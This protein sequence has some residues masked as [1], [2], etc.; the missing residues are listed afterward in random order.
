MTGV[1]LLG[2]MLVGALLNTILFGVMCGQMFT[3]FQRFPNDL[4]WIRLFIIYLLLVEIAVVVVEAG[5][6]YEPMVLNFGLAKALEKHPRPEVAFG[7]VVLPADPILI[8]LVST[9]IQVF[10]AWRIRVVTTSHILPIAICVLSAV[11]FGAGIFLTVMVA[12]QPA[13]RAFH[14]FSTETTVWLVSSAVCDVLIAGGMAHAL[15]TRKTG[16]TEVDGHINRIVRMSIETGSATAIAAIIDVV[17]ASTLRGTANFIVEFPLSTLYTCSLLA[18]LNSRLPRRTPTQLSDKEKD[19]GTGSRALLSRS[20][21]MYGNLTANW[22]ALGDGP[23]AT[24]GAGPFSDPTTFGKTNATNNFSSSN[25]NLSNKLSEEDLAVKAAEE[26]EK[27]PP[28]ARAHM[29]RAAASPTPAISTVRSRPNLKDVQKEWTKEKEEQQPVITSFNANAKPVMR[30][31]ILPQLV[32]AVEPTIETTTPATSN[33]PMK[34]PSP[35]TTRPPRAPVSHLR[36]PEVQANHMPTIS[37]TGVIT[38]PVPARTY[39][40]R[41]VK[42]PAHISTST[43]PTLRSRPSTRDLLATTN[44]EAAKPESALKRP[45]AP[46][47]ARERERKRRVLPAPPPSPLPVSAASVSAGI[48]KRAPTRARGPAPTVAPPP[49]PSSSAPTPESASAP[50]PALAQPSPDRHDPAERRASTTLPLLSALAN[51][52]P[53]KR[54]SSIAP[55]PKAQPAKD[56]SKE[57]LVVDEE[58]AAAARAMQMDDGGRGGGRARAPA[59]SRIRASAPPT[60]FAAFTVPIWNWTF[61]KRS[62]KAPEAEPVPALPTPPLVMDIGV[63]AEKP[64]T[65]DRSERPS[66]DE[67]RRAP[68]PTAALELDAAKAKVDGEPYSH[69]MSRIPF[70][71]QT[72]TAQNKPSRKEVRQSTAALDLAGDDGQEAVYPRPLSR[73]AVFEEPPTTIRISFPL[74][75]PM[76]ATGTRRMTNIPSFSHSSSH[77]RR[78][79][80]GYAFGH[81]GSS[82]SRQP[83]HDTLNS[84]RG[85]PRSITPTSYLEDERDSTSRRGSTRPRTPPAL[86]RL[87]E[88]ERNPFDEQEEKAVE[89]EQEDVKPVPLSR[90]GSAR[91]R[92]PPAPLELSAARSRT[93]L[94]QIVLDRDAPPTPAPT[95][96]ASASSRPR[97]PPAQIELDRE[98]DGSARSRTP[99]ATVGLGSSLRNP[100]TRPRTP[101]ARVELDREQVPVAESSSRRGSTRPRTPT[102]QLELNNA[103]PRTPTAQLELGGTR[104]RTPTALLELGSSRPRTPPA[105]VELQVNST[106]PRTPPAQ[107]ELN[108]LRPRTPPALLEFNSARP[109]T[110]PAHIELNRDKDDSPPFN[111][112]R[113]FGLGRGVRPRTPPAQLELAESKRRASN[114]PGL[115]SSPSANRI[116]GPSASANLQHKPSREDL[117]LRRMLS[118]TKRGGI[119]G[120]PPP[121]PEEPRQ[122]HTP[123]PTAFVSTPPS[124]FVT[125][126]PTAFVAPKPAPIPIP[127]ARNS[128][129]APKRHACEAAVTSASVPD[130]LDR[131]IQEAYAAAERVPPTTVLEHFREI[132]S[133]AVARYLSARK[134]LQR[135]ELTLIRFHQACEHE[136]T[137]SLVGNSIK[138]PKLQLLKGIEDLSD[139]NED[140]MVFKTTQFQSQVAQAKAAVGITLNATTYADALTAYATEIITDTSPDADVKIW[141][142]CILR[143][144]RAFVIEL[145]QLA[146]EFTAKLKQDA[147]AKEMKA[148]AVA[149]ANH[150][151]D[152]S[153]NPEPMRDIVDKGVKKGIE[154]L[155]DRVAELEKMMEK[156]TNPP[157]KSKKKPGPK[158]QGKATDT[159]K[160]TSKKAHHKTDRGEGG[161]GSGTAVKAKEKGKK[162]SKPK[163][164]PQDSDAE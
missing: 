93:P 86:H 55:A 152:T 131:A 135:A 14:S 20:G 2:P 36:V 102:A 143:F 1:D 45:Q 57:P 17:L 117:G 72:S 69:R 88:M 142:L 46:G 123:P 146:Y 108:G 163:P 92:T 81:S 71:D 129:G 114:R 16:F 136:A 29:M 65:M 42:T 33:A 100:F 38:E 121:S 112:T 25:L 7:N 78:N 61:G 6:I 156:K 118:A 150:T 115:P 18:M 91:P 40:K 26:L 148:D 90:Q 58:V 77:P 51:L 94:A 73:A 63:K 70:P 75:S 87:L 133:D 164:T 144:R 80:Q 137:P 60:A 98:R 101:P 28:I 105:Q 9:P 12:T 30:E 54:K 134:T 128:G 138:H 19:A 160:E 43:T 21:T 145:E 147:R 149:T 161:S 116:Y 52:A 151:A 24:S 34:I 74:F 89:K 82:H 49:I 110:P 50:T 56:E 162:K 41:P 5:I 15:V 47:G 32:L 59:V 109:R 104:P 140:L 83:S 155:A 130:P 85:F 122:L 10:T 97:T 11:S 48:A 84:W 64:T 95:A 35:P 66:R 111:R 62:S 158:D 103:R 119:F 157:K 113:E 125:P 141:D 154:P 120:I 153:N 68:T 27:M 13:F 79:T 37:E 44:T 3:Y 126:P 39:S 99:P 96:E 124:A 4:P 22:K 132:H 107:R 159:K 8:T 23:T 139:R 31:L 127:S 76:Q 67:A 53:S 106:R